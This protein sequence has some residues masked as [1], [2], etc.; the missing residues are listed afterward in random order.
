LEY[1]DPEMFMFYNAH[2]IY[3]EHPSGC[4]DQYFGFNKSTDCGEHKTNVITVREAFTAEI[5]LGSPGEVSFFK[6]IKHIFW[7]SISKEAFNLISETA[8]QKKQCIH[9]KHGI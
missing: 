1:F 2:T 7:S 6:I 9:Q 8:F 4:P 5:S 3:N